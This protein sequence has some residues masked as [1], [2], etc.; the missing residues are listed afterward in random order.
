VN[1]RT[2]HLRPALRLLAL[3]SFGMATLGQI[4]GMAVAENQKRVVTLPAAASIQGMAP[5]YSDVRVFNISYKD[6][7]TVTATYRCYIGN[8]CPGSAPQTTF[9]LPPRGSKSFDDMIASTFL[10]PNT[11]GAVEFAYSKSS[12]GGGGGDDDVLSLDPKEEGRAE[13]LLVTSRLYSTSPTPTVGMLIPGLSAAR[14]SSN[15][16]LTSVRNLGPGAGYRTNVGVFNPGETAVDVTFRILDGSSPVGLP[17]QT[18]V[19]AHSGVQLN[20]IFAQCGVGDLETARGTI[21]VNATGRV[22][23]YGVVIDNNTSD[24]YLILGTEDLPPQAISPVP[25]A[26]RTP[27]APGPTA[28]RTPTPPVPT[29]TA[30]PTTAPPG[31]TATH[32]PTQPGPTATRTPT[33]PGP[34]ATH[35]PTPP[36]PTATPTRTPTPPPPTPTRTPTPPPPPPTATPTPPAAE[37]RTVFVGGPGGSNIFVDSVEGGTDSHI[38]VGDTIHWLWTDTHHNTV[39]GSNCAPNGIWESPIQDSGTFDFTFTQAGTYP[40]Y[41]DPHCDSNMVGTIFVTP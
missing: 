18:T 4:G 2:V 10:A 31:P 7:L 29:A 28:T 8:P 13:S 24:P 37:T 12:G 38:H 6:R 1:G 25:T 35:T 5:F 30:T 32:T 34:T 40:Y 36:A 23:P 39:S 11:A 3:A 20:G 15:S 16:V 14:A 41:C 21:M 22:F 27:T 33:L 17:V 19:E 9:E 26:T